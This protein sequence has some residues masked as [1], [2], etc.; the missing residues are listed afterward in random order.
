MIGPRLRQ[1]RRDRGLTQI[2]F[3][4]I[5]QRKGW[6]ISRETLAKIES[7]CRWVADFEL[8]FFANV[9]ELTTVELLPD[10][11]SAGLVKRLVSKLERRLD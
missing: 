5:C 3:A 1:I 7:Q 8:V 6:D 9:L 4:S 10:A 11:E 2:A